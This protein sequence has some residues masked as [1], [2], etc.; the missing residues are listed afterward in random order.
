LLTC[1]RCTLREWREPFEVS[2]RRW[3]P[4]LDFQASVRDYLRPLEAH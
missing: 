4:F 1:L 2:V 3:H